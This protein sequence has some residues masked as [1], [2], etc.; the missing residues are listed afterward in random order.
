VTILLEHGLDLNRVNQGSLLQLA[1]KTDCDVA[2]MKMLLQRGLDPALCADKGGMPLWQLSI[3]R[4]NPELASLLLPSIDSWSCDSDI[5]NNLKQSN[6]VGEA[7]VN[8]SEEW[9]RLLENVLSRGVKLL[10]IFEPSCLFDP[11]VGLCSLR[12]LLSLKAD[13]NVQVKLSAFSHVVKKGP[14]R[15]VQRSPNT[16]YTPLQW[17]CALTSKEKKELD[18]AY[19][20]D[21]VTF[22]LEAKADVNAKNSDGSTA[23]S[24]AETDSKIGPLLL[25]HRQVQ[26]A[27]EAETLSVGETKKKK[28]KKKKKSAEEDVVKEDASLESPDVA[29]EKIIEPEIEV[30]LGER[31]E[32]HLRRMQKSMKSV[33]EDKAHDIMTFESHHCCLCERVKDSCECQGTEDFVQEQREAELDHRRHGGNH[34][35]PLL[36]LAITRLKNK[37]ENLH[38]NAGALANVT[39]DPQSEV[40][41]V[42]RNPTLEK[43]QM[44][45][46]ETKEAKEEEKE[47]DEEEEQPAEATRGAELVLEKCPDEAVSLEGCAWEVVVSPTAKDTLFGKALGEKLKLK[48][49]RQ[50]RELAEGNWSKKKAKK[51]DGVPDWLRNRLFETYLTKGC[52]IIWEVAVSYS[53]IKRSYT[54]MIRLWFIETDHDN[55]PRRIEYIINSLRR[56]RSST[57]QKKLQKNNLHH[58]VIK[59]FDGVDVHIPK[60]YDRSE[61]VHLTSEEDEVQR[62]ADETREREQGVERCYP[63]AEVGNTNNYTILK[64]YSMTAPFVSAFLRSAT[65]GKVAVMSDFPFCADETEDEFIQLG[66]LSRQTSSLILVGRSGTGKTTIAL[67]RMWAFHWLAEEKEEKTCHQIFITA[68]SVLRAS[69]EKK[70]Q[71]LQGVTGTAAKSIDLAK[72]RDKD[73]PLFLTSKEWLC[74]LDSLLPGEKFLTEEE[75]QGGGS[76][77]EEGDPLDSIELFDEDSDE[78]DDFDDRK[79]LDAAGAVGRR[80]KVTFEFFVETLWPIMIKNKPTDYSPS[81]IF[82]HIFSY[83]KGSYESVDCPKGRLTFEQYEA[84]GKKV[85]SG[86]R[87]EAEGFGSRAEVYELFEEYEK[88]KRLKHSYDSSDLVFSV[89]QRLKSGYNGVA[90]DSIVIDEV[91]DFTQSELRLFLMACGDKNRLFLTG[92]TAQTIARGVGFRFQD[93]KSIFYKEAEKAKIE[94]TAPVGVPKVDMLTVN[95]RTHSGIL[96]CASSV[97]DLMQKLFPETVDTDVPRE[98]AH[99]SGPK[100]FLL[101]HST[102]EELCCLLASVANDNETTIEFGAHQAILVRD[103]ASKDKLPTEFEGALVLT[104]IESKGLE[105]DDVILFNFFT[106]SPADDEWRCISGYQQKYFPEENPTPEEQREIRELRPLE[107]DPVKYML[108]GE[109]LKHLYVAITR[110]R[111]RL[112]FFET[113]VKKRAHMFRYFEKRGLVQSVSV[114]Q[115][116]DSEHVPESHQS[117]QQGFWD[118]SIKSTAEDWRNRGDNLMQNRIYRIAAECYQKSGDRFKEQKARGL[119]CLRDAKREQDQQT[120]HDLLL[121]GCEAFLSASDFP[122]AGECLFGRGDYEKAARVFE[123]CGDGK[124]AAK[125]YR[126]MSKTVID[127]Q[128]QAALRQK[129]C[130]AYE[131]CGLLDEALTLYNKEQQFEECCALLNKYPDYKPTGTYSRDYFLEAYASACNRHKKHKEAAASLLQLRNVDR[132]MALASKWDK[133]H[134]VYGDVLIKEMKQKG[135]LT[136]AG[137]YMAQAGRTDEAIEFLNPATKADDVSRYIHQ[138]ENEIDLSFENWRENIIVPSFEQQPNAAHV[139]LCAQYLKKELPSHGSKLAE[140]MQHRALLKSCALLTLLVT[141]E[142]KNESLHTQL[143]LCVA[144]AM[145]PGQSLV[146]LDQNTNMKMIQLKDAFTAADL[147]VGT[148]LTTIL[149]LRHESVKQKQFLDAFD[150]ARKKARGCKSGTKAHKAALTEVQKYANLKRET[151]LTGT[152][153]VTVSGKLFVPSDQPGESSVQLLCKI[154]RDFESY[155][156]SL[157]GCV[158]DTQATKAK[159][160]QLGDIVLMKNGDD[161]CLVKIMSKPGEVESGNMSTIGVKTCHLWNASSNKIEEIV[162]VQIQQLHVLK[163]AVQASSELHLKQQQCFSF[164]G[165][166]TGAADQTT[167]PMTNTSLSNLQ[168]MV[169]YLGSTENSEKG[170]WPLYQPELGSNVVSVSRRQF[171]DM[172]AQ[173]FSAAAELCL[174]MAWRLR[175]EVLC[176]DAVEDSKKHPIMWKDELSILYTR[177]AILEGAY[178]AW[179]DLRLS[180]PAR[181]KAFHCSQFVSKPKCICG[182]AACAKHAAS[183]F[184]LLPQDLQRSLIHQL[185]LEYKQSP[186]NERRKDF[187]AAF[188][189]LGQLKLSDDGQWQST[190]TAIKVAANQVAKKDYAKLKT[191]TLPMLVVLSITEHE[192]NRAPERVLDEIYA[193]HGR[194]AQ[195]TSVDSGALSWNVATQVYEKALMIALLA[196]QTPDQLAMDLILPASLFER[197]F[198]SN[199]SLFRETSDFR[200]VMAIKEKALAFACTLLGKLTTISCTEHTLLEQSH[201]WLVLIVTFLLNMWS[202]RVQI[203]DDIQSMMLNELRRI[204]PEIFFCLDLANIDI[205]MRQFLQ[206]ASQVMSFSETELL[207]VELYKV[208][209]SKVAKSHQQGNIEF[210]IQKMNTDADSDACAELTGGRLVKNMTYVPGEFGV[211][212]ATHFKQMEEARE[213]KANQEWWTHLVDRVLIRDRIMQLKGCQP[214]MRITMIRRW[215]VIKRIQ[216]RRRKLMAETGRKSG[217]ENKSRSEELMIQHKNNLKVTRLDDGLWIR[218][219]SDSKC[220]LCGRDHSSESPEYLQKVHD[221][222]EPIFER[223]R[224][225]YDTKVCPLLVSLDLTIE[226][227]EQ[228]VQENPH[229]K[230]MLARI[231]SVKYEMKSTL[232]GIHHFIKSSVTERKWLNIIFGSIEGLMEIKLAKHKQMWDLTYT[233]EVFRLQCVFPDANWASQGA[234]GGTTEQTPFD[235]EEDDVEDDI[236]VVEGHGRGKQK[237]PRRHAGKRHGSSKSKGV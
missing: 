56:G 39:H 116:Q 30:P 206:A 1:V 119:N 145:E 153:Y 184:E 215:L 79:L 175:Y 187:N 205:N 235:D 17:L 208:A 233:H 137:E 132:R 236:M 63:P 61:V 180:V 183:A 9:T 54:D 115:G 211:I 203:N 15:G 182:V 32:N 207:T 218:H 94:G 5:V 27:A 70:F 230:A 152:V 140:K 169:Q 103:Q 52:R 4:K 48:A 234:E 126:K 134:N 133:E 64:F 166:Q 7:M 74:A 37:E 191:K 104:I 130:L 109:E 118:L 122:R 210:D 163:D 127:K 50:L 24:L 148:M 129:A 91:Q 102:T 201:S 225:Y 99:F 42:D 221:D 76:W 113:D 21:T 65:H 10:D 66:M 195:A 20:V 26:T 73:F 217:R 67:N 202:R 23:M 159:R 51:L 59:D 173:L 81:S 46:K 197:Y 232:I 106:D 168:Y 165:L 139:L 188:N 95:Y 121:H 177:R 196:A 112:S 117:Q 204:A 114:L 38:R 78:E 19:I 198:R 123:L 85:A 58:E 11:N 96:N 93:V 199:Y 33:W 68:N 14:G 92:D 162:P 3:W 6:L 47:V 136:Q 222:Y 157:K 49:I 97:V 84:L 107:F 28:R 62:L 86:F 193:V 176:D 149:Q 8:G 57:V 34:E 90:I 44:D 172:L 135:E 229:D 190:F 186:G 227:L 231:D 194:M 209:Y 80:K 105:F 43:Q 178:E 131:D 69:V 101:P 35:D 213:N 41:I 40:V 154:A 192:Q 160:F 161:D 170:V 167:I 60:T 226:Q 224:A 164:F 220:S 200:P 144:K 16:T 31:V 125:C 237:K 36:S 228:I 212:T 158:I 138:T 53:T 13:V 55:V 25:A 89:Y 181:L 142:A 219:D 214:P 179:T 146:R 75:T 189:R 12:R 141:D 143:T 88:A 29:L 98:Q 147:T 71:S 110:S 87:S 108:L 216:R 223:F 174:D 120:R 2:L 156:K 100:P 45:E 155:W 18:S 185:I 151:K 150:A 128:Q 124:H 77:H 82:T 22:L 83:I 111:K 171:S 72:M